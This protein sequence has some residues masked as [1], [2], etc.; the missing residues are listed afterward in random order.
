MKTK[1]RINTSRHTLRGISN[2]HWCG[3]LKESKAIKKILEGLEKKKVIGLLTELGAFSK[4]N[5]VWLRSKVYGDAELEK[6]L[7][8]YRKKIRGAFGERVELRIARG[9]L[10][11]FKRVS[12]NIESFID[13]MLYYVECG[14][15]FSLQYGDM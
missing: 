7:N 9:A 4:E 11:D 12:N 8:F 2:D 10:N 5:G 14:T 15:N 6:S 13:L 1:I 3:L